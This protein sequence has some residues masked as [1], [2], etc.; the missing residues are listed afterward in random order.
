MYELN[1]PSVYNFDGEDDDKKKEAYKKLYYYCGRLEREYK[2]LVT[3]VL[4]YPGS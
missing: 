2:A 3:A 1:I 4:S